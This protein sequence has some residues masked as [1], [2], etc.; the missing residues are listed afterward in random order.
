MILIPITAHPPHSLHRELIRT[1]EEQ[2]IEEVVFM[3][4]RVEHIKFCKLLLFFHSR[5]LVFGLMLAFNIFAWLSAYSH[6]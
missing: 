4:D 6:R 1:N 5:E 3:Y 2:R